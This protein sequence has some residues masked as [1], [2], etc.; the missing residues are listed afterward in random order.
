MTDSIE[1]ERD[2]SND[3]VTFKLCD[4]RSQNILSSIEGLG[5]DVKRIADG[6]DGTIKEQGVKLEKLSG[7]FIRM[8]TRVDSGVL[9]R[10][11]SNKRAVLVVSGI[12]VLITLLSNV[13]KIANLWR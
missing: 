13:D 12:M 3:P 9:G 7:D 2:V 5:A 11:F 6:H 8:Q 1:E 4:E 10:D